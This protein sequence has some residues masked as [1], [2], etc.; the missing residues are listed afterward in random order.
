MDISSRGT[1]VWDV[2]NHAVRY[3]AR[4][5]ASKDNS[6][7]AIWNPFAHVHRGETETSGTESSPVQ[8]G[9]AYSF[10]TPQRAATTIPSERQTQH[11]IF[12]SP[13]RTNTAPAAAPEFISN[14]RKDVSDT[15]AVDT[16]AVPKK[17]TRFQS[18]F[19]KRSES[20][21]GEDFEEIEAYGHRDRTYLGRDIK[22]VQQWWTLTR[23][24][25]L[26]R[27]LRVIIF[28]SWFNVLL[29]FVPT[30]FAVNYAHVTPA[31]VFSINFVAIIPMASLM[32]FATEELAIRLGDIYGGLLSMTFSNAVQLI[33]SVLLLKKRQIF[34]LKMSL[35]GYILSNL[36]FLTGLGFFLGGLGRLEQYFDPAIAQTIGM[37]LLLAV[38]SVVVPTT[39]H[40]MTDTTPEG[41]LGQ[42]RGT[43]VV[44]LVSYGLYVLFQYVTNRALYEIGQPKVRKAKPRPKTEI[45]DG[46]LFMG[47]AAIGAGTAA[48]AGGNI[49]ST[50]LVKAIKED[51]D[52][53]E[54]ADSQEPRISLSVGIILLI[55]SVVLLAFNSQ[56]ATDNLQGL[57]EH[58]GLS[59]TFVGLVIIPIL[60]NDPQSIKAAML[61]KMDMSIALT[62][63][64]CMQTALMVVPCIVLVAWGM[65]IDD[66]TL[67]FDAFTTAALFAS[68][69]IVTY[70]VQEGKSNWLTGAL[71]IKVYIIISISA[72]YRK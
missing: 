36:L 49:H 66:M 5:L 35:L 54:G 56:F 57:L 10:T 8:A 72:F 39:A 43:A 58:T 21:V 17:Q 15:T 51:E 22:N 53:D 16:T 60:S 11:E 45:E 31:L 65:R 26:G 3:R 52:E 47:M 63:E 29:V 33:T 61:D 62:L 44:I 55:I 37:L 13:Y 24:L 25:P 67:E 46:A 64:R 12:E 38:L 28:G 40:L 50:Q 71:L 68:I 27:Q 1:R 19:R 9:P 20:D 7:N 4:R 48:A 59:Q 2:Q 6:G 34:V 32:G 18:I 23:Q 14:P 41:I 42:S 69:I 70:V 30:G